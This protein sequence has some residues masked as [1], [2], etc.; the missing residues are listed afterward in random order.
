[1]YQQFTGRNGNQLYRKT[2]ETILKW[3]EPVAPRGLPTQEIQ[4][5]TT[6]LEP[7]ERIL[8]VPGRAINPFFNVAEN[9]AIIAGLHAQKNWFLRWNKNYVEVAH[10]KLP[11]G[12][13]SEQAWAF[14]GT[15]LRHWPG[16]ERYSHVDQLKEITKKLQLDKVSRQAVAS[17]W[18]PMLDNEPGHRD[19]PCNWGV[20]FKIRDDRLHMTV[21][22]R[23]NDVHWGLYAVNLSQFS[24]LQEVLANILGVEIGHQIHQSDSLHLYFDEAHE[25][26]T[27]NIRNYTDV[28]FDIYDYVKPTPMFTK[29]LTWDEI[30]QRLVIFFD[31]YFND[32]F[33]SSGSFDGWPFLY[34]AI[35]FLSAYTVRKADRVMSINHLNAVKDSAL[36]VSGVEYIVRGDKHKVIDLRML[37][38]EID[39]RFRDIPDRA[40][41]LQY[42]LSGNALNGTGRLVP[43]SLARLP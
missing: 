12:E 27:H 20:M 18:H 31:H 43:A 35:N 24:F 10:D 15:R 3:G 9:L 23:S 33:I 34:D 28:T 36:W 26:I 25:E 40:M 30:D 32:A 8:T 4:A 2:L 14:Y 1:M 17:L 13:Y 7:R 41:I 37:E 29:Q 5:T 21:I 16:S 19:Y 22:N 39:R 42:I 38:A 6:I 11:D